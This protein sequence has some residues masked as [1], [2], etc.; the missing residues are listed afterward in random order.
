MPHNVENT[1]TLAYKYRC[2]TLA[3]SLFSGEKY[4]CTPALSILMRE[5]ASHHQLVAYKSQ[6]HRVE[7]IAGYA[8][9]HAR[10]MC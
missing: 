8:S 5:K 1:E 4:D 2:Q 10:E 9:S 7:N 3:P 6:P